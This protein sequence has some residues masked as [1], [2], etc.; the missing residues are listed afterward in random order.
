MNSY[1][2]SITCFGKVVDRRIKSEMTGKTDFN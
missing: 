1:K 2:V